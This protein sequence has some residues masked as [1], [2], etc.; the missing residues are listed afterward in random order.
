MANREL[1]AEQLVAFI[2]AV[3]KKENEPVLPEVRATMAR[4]VPKNRLLIVSEKCIEKLTDK[5]C[6]HLDRILETMKAACR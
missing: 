4:V 3:Y 1:L 6:A 2:A 5:D